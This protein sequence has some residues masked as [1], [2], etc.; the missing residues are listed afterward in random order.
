[1]IQYIFDT[2]IVSYIMKRRFPKLQDRYLNTPSTD[3]AISAITYGEI[4]FGIEPLPAFHPARVRAVSFLPSI[5]VLDWPSEAAGHYAK[6]RHQ[7]RN[8][9]IGD[10]DAMIA[11]HAMAINATLVT[12][13]TRHFGRIGAP[14]QIDN[15]LW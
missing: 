5:R 7:T 15:W 13:N 10:R 9:P 12:N 8:Q 6:I 1:V 3:F 4:L 2:D 14:L 11:A